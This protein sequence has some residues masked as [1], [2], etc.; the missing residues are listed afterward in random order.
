MGFE[1]VG[2]SWE[3]WVLGL[4]GGSWESRVLGVVRGQGF[5]GLCSAWDSGLWQELGTLGNH[6]G[7]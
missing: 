7:R 1:T 4:L 6:H 5:V 3:F 2:G